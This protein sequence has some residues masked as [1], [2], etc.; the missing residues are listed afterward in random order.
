MTRL[1]VLVLFTLVWAAVT[2]SFTVLNLGFGLLISG[3]AL[4]LIRESV[5]PSRIAVRPLKVLALIVLFFRELALSAFKVAVLVTRR[6]MNLKPGILAFP[7][8][9]DRDFEITLLANLIT[10]TPGTLSV[11][12]SQDRR[13]LY[14]HALDC[15][16]PA[17]TIRDIAD[18]FEAKILEAFR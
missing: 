8:K 1:V 18:G 7:L 13:F 14:V 6:D 10:L 11:D 2:G 17:A 4:F 9:V 15:A 16:D 5:Q 3:L 12:V